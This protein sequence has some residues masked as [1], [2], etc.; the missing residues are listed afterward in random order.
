MELTPNEMRNHTFPSAMRGY[1]KAEVDAYIQAAADALEEARAQLVALTEEREALENRYDELKA[2]QD[3]IKAAVL[4]AQKS[5]EEIKANAR[6][7]AELIISEAKHRRDKLIDEKYQKLSE[8]EARI[9]ELEY[10]KKSFYN[11]LRAEIEAHLRL[12]DS[13]LPPENKSPEQNQ[14]KP[15]YT[16]EP[17]HEP[18]PESAPQPAPEP[19][20]EPPRE[21]ERDVPRFD[22]RDE[23][24]DNLVDQLGSEPPAEEEE[25]EK[26][27]EKVENGQP[28][29]N[30]F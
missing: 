3:T 5:G 14:P 6:K 30:D 18:A 23:D 15:T 24:I 4:E 8:I 12:V 2:M 20:P 1:N 25:E 21:P 28:Q 16:P 7:E 29:G 27:K 26:E 19:P 13:I 17:V 22:A 9:H 11:K 10:T